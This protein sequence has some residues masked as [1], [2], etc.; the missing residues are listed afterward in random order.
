MEVLF[1]LALAEFLLVRG[2]VGTIVFHLKDR[3]FF[4]SDAMPADVHQVVDHL[5]VAPDCPSRELGARLSSHLLDATLLLTEDSFWASGHMYRELPP[6]IGSELAKSDLVVLKGDVNYRRLLDD[7]HWPHTTPIERCAGY[8]PAPFLLLRTLKGEIMVGL[9]PGQAEDLSSEDPA[10]LT[11]G[12]R[13]IV[14][15]VAG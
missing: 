8:F 15:L 12:K 7:R 2:H 9:A 3:P 6:R 13:G 4:V 5:Q 1:D 10:W 14:Q 11:N